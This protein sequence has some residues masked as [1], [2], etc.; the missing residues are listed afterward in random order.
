MYSEL[1]VGS[2]PLVD[3]A[4][5]VRRRKDGEFGSDLAADPGWEILLQLYSASLNGERLRLDQFVGELPLSAL[6]RWARLLEEQGFVE[7]SQ[8]GLIGAAHALQLTKLGALKMSR[9]F[10]AQDG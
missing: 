2:E 5:A 1:I 7:W 6:A 3:A 9:V 8:E 10:G 4:L